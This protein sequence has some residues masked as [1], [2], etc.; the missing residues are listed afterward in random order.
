MFTG[1]V[2]AY[3]A[4]THVEPKT[5]AIEIQLSRPSH[6]DDLKLDRYHSM[7]LFQDLRKLGIRAHFWP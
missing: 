1:L 7:K 3:S 5:N 4:I 2:E 6:F